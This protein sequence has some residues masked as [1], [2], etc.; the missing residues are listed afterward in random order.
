MHPI[1]RTLL[2]FLA[3][4]AFAPGAR[5]VLEG[6]GNP[7]TVQRAA[8]GMTTLALAVPADLELVQGPKEG[9]TLTA[10]D[11]IL[12]V[13]QTVV[14]DGV[15]HVRF[16]SGEEPVRKRTCRASRWR[17]RVGSTRRRSPRRA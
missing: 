15:L 16:R 9:L 13:I 11:N 17:A 1:R 12:R 3:L 8:K 7:A 5:A 14:E 6:S 10:D 2:A 4:A